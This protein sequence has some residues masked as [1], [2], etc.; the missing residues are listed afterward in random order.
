MS[1]ESAGKWFIAATLFIILFCGCGQR[2]DASDAGIT[3]RVT[4]TA[5]THDSIV[6][7]PIKTTGCGKAS[8]AGQGKTIAATLTSDGLQR[9][10]RLHIPTGY[11]SH[12]MTPLVLD[13]HGMNSTAQEQER[14]S[15]Y[16]ALADQQ[17]FLVAY[18]Q[19]T[20]GSDGKTG[21]ATY[22]KYDPTVND[23]LFFSDLLNT[24][25]KQ[26]CVDATRIYATGMSNGG[27]MTNLLACQMAGRIAAFVPVAAAIYPIPGG[28]HPG[29]PVP[30]LEFH[31]VDD[32]I[33][34][35][36]GGKALKFAPVMQTMQNWA[37]LDGCTG[38]PTTFFQQADVTGMKWT[39]CKGKVEVQHYSVNDGGHT[40][41]GA[42]PV[43][44]LGKTTRTVSATTL[45]WQFFQHYS[46]NP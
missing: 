25:Q 12:K 11:N 21:W 16:S 42:I 34:H 7:S 4:T 18:P 39:G 17:H 40:W 13:I 6:N 33:V 9:T 14:Y 19:G 31:G 32:P 43:P 41:P 15:Q 1:I 28:C 23:V 46:F 3:S 37:T 8:P 35:Y 44:R 45:G 27:G 20:V 38:G 24:L 30:Y 10:Y 5:N 29:R 36:N 2:T 22:G 26:L